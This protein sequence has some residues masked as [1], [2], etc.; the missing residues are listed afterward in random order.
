MI[1]ANLDGVPVKGWRGNAG[2]QPPIFRARF[3]VP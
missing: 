2:Y 1:A 3:A